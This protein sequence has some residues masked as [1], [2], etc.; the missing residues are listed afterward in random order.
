MYL[1]R[2]NHRKTRFLAMKKLIFISSFLV[3]VFQMQAQ[4]QFPAEY[5]SILC[6]RAFFVSGEEIH[7]S[8]N[9]T[10]DSDEG[11]LS[12]VVYIELIDPM[13]NKINQQKSY[14]DGHIFKGNMIIPESTI[15]GYYILRSYTQWMRNT[16]AKSFDQ[17]MIKIVNPFLLD[18]Q[19]L[20]DSLSL[21]KE[22]LSENIEFDDS[23][24]N[25][26]YKSSDEIEINLQDFEIENID[27]VQISIIPYGSQ[28][29]TKTEEKSLVRYV[30]AVH[31]LP[32]TRG[33]SL[34]G[35]I[36]VNGE[37]SPYH[38]VNLNIMGEKDFLSVFTD[39]IGKFHMALPKY[40]GIQEL[41]IG[42]QEKA[43][44]IEILIDNDF[45]V[46]AYNS[47][48]Y[49]FEL[50]QQEKELALQ[51]A[52]QYQINKWYFDSISEESK[53]IK[54]IP[55]YQNPFKTIDFDYYILLD[56]VSQYFTDISSYVLVK[57]KNGKRY[58]QII[59]EES[60]FMVY[61]PLLMVDWIPINNAERIFAMN[62]ANI[63][64]IEVLNRMFYHG[65][66]TYGGIIHVITRD[67]KMSDL[68]FPESNLYLNYQF[69]ERE[70]ND[71]NLLQ[72]PG[73]SIN[74]TFKGE[75]ISKLSFNTPKLPGKYIMLIQ[76]LDQSGNKQRFE[77]PFDVKD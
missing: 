38:L 25:E 14:L 74:K 36:I 13:G 1:K 16:G 49:D 67:G 73:T 48:V 66:N 12:T 62:P 69:P 64:K 33:L 72:F 15:S 43:G 10:T 23:I 9:V 31:Y 3:F 21:D 7:F 4:N 29:F 70:T 19:K 75:K 5:S 53:K 54:S 57:R 26:T 37:K 20:P 27:L 45:D 35:T 30:E 34:H 56:S 76:T 22:K 32:E 58:L 39:S 77:L 50:S 8:G 28:N 42:A 18:V 71:E 68:R 55:F 65:N 61:E 11:I 47:H 2:R 60:G 41:M 46:D 51:L 59:G 24:I 44:D 52:K 40:Y 6:D 17:I 63:Q